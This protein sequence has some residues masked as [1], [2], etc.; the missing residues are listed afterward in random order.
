MRMRLVLGLLLAVLAAIVGGVLLAAETEP[1]KGLVVPGDAISAYADRLR[2]GPPQRQGNLVLFPVFA[3]HVRV[4]DADLGLDKALALDLIEISELTTAEVNRVRVR[5]RAKRPVF[6]MGGEMLEGAKQDRIVGDDIVIP[7]GK[8]VTIPVFCVEHGRW[9]AKT[10]SFKS[11][12]TVAGASVRRSAKHGQSAVWSQVAEEQERLAAPSSTG[13]LSSVRDSEV[14]QRKAR[15]YTEA[16]SDLPED[17]P[18][19]RGVVAAVGGEIIAADLFS[20]RSLLEQLWPKLLESYVIEALDRPRSGASLQ[21]ASV[22]RWLRGLSRAARVPK[23]TP[24]AGD[25]YELRGAGILG[26]ALVWD[27]G[28][29]HMELFADEGLEPVRFNRLEFR[30]QRLEEGEPP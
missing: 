1:A 27:G 25:L 2:V 21:V 20:S 9:V 28:V 6:I 12:R 16:L 14:V 11:G 4:P 18:E 5:N 30:R 10:E 15:P 23:E 29:A 17:F 8:E 22:Q 26:S 19:A 13:A 3:N 24:G 7:P